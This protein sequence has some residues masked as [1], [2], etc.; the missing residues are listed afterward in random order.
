MNKCPSSGVVLRSHITLP[1]QPRAKISKV[2]VYFLLVC[3]TKPTDIFNLYTRRK[4]R[5]Y[6]IIKI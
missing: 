2:L 5:A 1:S 6:T 3:E 4:T